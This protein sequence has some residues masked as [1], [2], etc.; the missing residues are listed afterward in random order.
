MLPFGPQR[1][2]DDVAGMLEAIRQTDVGAA[3]LK[4]AGVDNSES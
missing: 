3:V 2:L 1:Q 4:R